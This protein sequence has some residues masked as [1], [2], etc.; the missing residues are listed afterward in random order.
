MD[1]IQ[2]QVLYTQFNLL[3]Y[4]YK[5]T[6]TEDKYEQNIRKIINYG[7]TIGHANEFA[8]Q[9]KLLHG[10]FAIGKVLANMLAK[11]HRINILSYE[12][13]IRNVLLKY[14]QPIEIPEP[15]NIQDVLKYLKYDKKVFKHEINFIFIQEFVKHKFN[16]T[17][18]KMDM[19]KK[20]TC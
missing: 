1:L 3:L 6:I 17:N 5:G 11:E 16:T 8:S 2:S 4:C 10:E 9:G 15:V 14:E 19:I 13:R 18:I 12:N 20:N 7:H